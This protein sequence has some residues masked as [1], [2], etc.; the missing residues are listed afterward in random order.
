MT[1]VSVA[2]LAWLAVETRRGNTLGLPE[3]LSSSAQTSWP[4]V[5][6]FALW[7]GQ[8]PRTLGGTTADGTR[9]DRGPPRQMVV[10]ARTAVGIAQ[11]VYGLPPIRSVR[12]PRSTL[13]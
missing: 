5:V 13:Y 11:R 4:F 2:G 6:A 10:Y 7:R 9:D 3:R 1:A 12:M 8:T